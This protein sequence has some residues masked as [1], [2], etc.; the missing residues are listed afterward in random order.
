MI[1]E[2]RK[3]CWILLAIAALLAGGLSLSGDAFAR[4]GGGGGRGGGRG[5]GGGARGKRSK[6]GKQ[7]DRKELIE[8]LEEE[9]RAAD[10]DQRFTTGRK[11]N[12]ET[13]H[14][15]RRVEVLARHRRRG[16][17]ARRSDDSP[18]EVGR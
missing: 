18:P 9:M 12:F 6:N 14:R 4:G 11:T 5:G 1:P 10:R 3:R 17:D 8:Q 15:E 7:L 13:G 16:E 2:P